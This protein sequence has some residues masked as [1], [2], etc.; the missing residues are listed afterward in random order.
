M[1]ARHPAWFR[2]DLEALFGL[3]AA[4]RIAPRVVGR[5]SL[6]EVAE[7]HRRLEAGGLDGK[8]VRALADPEAAIAFMVFRWGRATKAE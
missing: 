8:L 2:H 5:I 6:N 7:A 3:L 1:R 4:H